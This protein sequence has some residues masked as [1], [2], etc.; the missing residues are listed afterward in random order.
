[1]ETFEGYDNWATTPPEE[2]DCGRCEDAN[3][4]GRGFIP[5]EPRIPENACCDCVCHGDPE[6]I[7]QVEADFKYEQMKNGDFESSNEAR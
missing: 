5:G 6:I 2:D 7:A 1:M 4:D 3:C